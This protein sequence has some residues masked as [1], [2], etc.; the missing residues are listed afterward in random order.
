MLKHRGK[1]LNSF[2]SQVTTAPIKAPLR[3]TR[4][5][6]FMREE[7]GMDTIN[8]L[9][10]ITPATT[11][12]TIWN[13]NSTLMTKNKRQPVRTTRMEPGKRSHRVATIKAPKI[14]VVEA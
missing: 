3:T 5:K 9:V 13:S 10:G 6:I 14:R 8:Q 1:H 12:A 7:V 2:S 4:V 11:T